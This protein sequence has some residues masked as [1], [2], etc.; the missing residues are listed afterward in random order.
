MSTTATTSCE[1]GL[2][3]GLLLLPILPIDLA[4]LHCALAGT[5]KNCRGGSL[6]RPEHGRPYEVVFIVSWQRQFR[7]ERILRLPIRKLFNSLN[8]PNGHAAR[9][10]N[11][12]SFMNG[13]MSP[14]RT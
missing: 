14:S 7:H 2:E 10:C 11:K 12:Y 1:T 4:H 9:F 3:V 8:S 13:S 5:P 6:G